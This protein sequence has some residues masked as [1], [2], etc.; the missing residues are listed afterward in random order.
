MDKEY[1]ASARDPEKV[2]QRKLKRGKRRMERRKYGHN[3]KRRAENKADAAAKRKA[4]AQAAIVGG[5]SRAGQDSGPVGTG[6]ID[7]GT[8]TYTGAEGGSMKKTNPKSKKVTI[9]GKKATVK[10]TGVYKNGK[11]VGEVGSKNLKLDKNNLKP[12][13]AA[14]AAAAKK[15]QADTK[16]GGPKMKQPKVV[17]NKNTSMSVPAKKL[18]KIQNQSA[19]GFTPG[20]KK[21]RSIVGENTGPVKMDKK[22]KPYSLLMEDSQ[23][24][25]KGDTIRPGKAP[26]VGNYIMGGDYKVKDMG[27]KNYKITGAS[28]YDKNYG[29]SMN[30]YQ[31]KEA[32]MDDYSHEKKLKADGRYEAAEGK[33]ANAKNDFDHA[34]ALKKDAHYDAKGRHAILKHMKKF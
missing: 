32:S 8:F 14:L 31:D 16:K 25:M 1:G 5:D 23:G 33:M 30:A 11:Y 18:V 21:Y 7:S 22:G 34:H 4:L 27:N 10:G 9:K 19:K 29:S 15:K 3:K 2:K 20:G 12:S 26:M 6:S 17:S 24:L 28:M 13:K